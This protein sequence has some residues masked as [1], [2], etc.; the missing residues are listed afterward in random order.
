MAGSQAVGVYMTGRKRKQSN[1]N[2]LLP[3][4]WTVLTDSVI[5]APLIRV[6]N[7]EC[8]SPFIGKILH[9]QPISTYILVLS[10]RLWV[11]TKE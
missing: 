7:Q 8:L 10:V 3:M 6:D 11:K 4:L 9:F 5:A 1:I 2:Q